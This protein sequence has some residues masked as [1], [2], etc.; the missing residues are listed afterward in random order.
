MGMSMTSFRSVTMSPFKGGGGGG[1]GGMCCRD[2]R[3]AAGGPRP[4]RAPRRDRTGGVPPAPPRHPEGLS[5]V[6]GCRAATLAS[7]G[8]PECRNVGT[9]LHRFGVLL[10]L[11]SAATRFGVVPFAAS[12]LPLPR[13]S[14][15]AISTSVSEDSEISGAAS[16]RGLT[17]ST[18]VEVT[19]LVTR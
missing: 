1:G 18:M 11:R 13:R 9:L 16:S 4:A 17:P 14:P 12:L 2:S 3:R 6:P 10:C 7:R 15:T 5:C 19:A 8:R